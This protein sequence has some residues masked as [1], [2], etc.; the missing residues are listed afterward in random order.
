VSFASPGLSKYRGPLSHRVNSVAA[1]TGL[2]RSQIYNLMRD[3]SL[4][5][6]TVGKIR[7]VRDRDVRRLLKIEESSDT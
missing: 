4:P 6:I 3:G 1:L 7:L 2:C 5:F